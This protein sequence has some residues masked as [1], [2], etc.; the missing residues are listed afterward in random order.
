V[1]IQSRKEDFLRILKDLGVVKLVIDYSGSGDSGQID[2]I[3]AF[4]SS[5]VETD[6]NGAQDVD[7]L[8]K[9]H[10]PAN[11]IAMRVAG[12]LLDEKDE[13]LSSAL[14]RFA[15]DA[16]ES[17]NVEDWCNNDGGD[18]IMTIYVEAGED[19]GEPYPAGHIQI[20]HGYNVNERHAVPY[21]L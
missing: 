3:S 12:V 6:P 16:L 9:A 10:A 15:Y 1:S 4:R 18:G 20:N 8:V 14:E 5:D 11:E 7:E 21:E 17:L 13:S 19:E 2:T